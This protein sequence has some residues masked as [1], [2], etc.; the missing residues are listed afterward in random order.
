MDS[1]YFIAAAKGFA[2]PIVW[3]IGFLA[4]FRGAVGTLWGSMSDLG[5]IAAVGVGVGGFILLAW[6]AALMFRDVMA[7]AFPEEFPKR[8]T[9]QA[10]EPSEKKDCP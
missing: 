6:V 8:S 4:L 3:A 5:M 1:R 9:Y 10:P 7:T 2:Y